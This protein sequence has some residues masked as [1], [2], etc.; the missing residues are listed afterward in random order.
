MKGSRILGFDRKARSLPPTSCHAPRS[1]E[2]FRA[3]IEQEFCQGSGIDPE[4]FEATIAVEPNLKQLP[5]GEVETPLHNA[6]NWQFRRFRQQANAQQYGALFLNE[7]GSCW[8]A[9]L[10]C[11]NWDAT[12]QQF[13]KYES[14]YQGGSRAYLPVINQATRRKIAARYG[15]DCPPAGKSFWRWL[16]GHPEIPIIW[17]EGGKKALCLL[18]DGYVAIALFGV[19]GGHRSKD[20]LGNA[21]L[22]YL[23]PDVQRFCQSGR[24]HILAFDQDVKEQ[25]RQKVTKALSSLAGLLAKTGGTV[26]IAQWDPA[27]GKGVDNLVVNQGRAAWDQAYEQALSLE[28]WL[29]HT[30]RSLTYRAQVVVNQRYLG[31][32]SIPDSARLICLKAPKGTGKTEAMIAL[33]QEAIERGQRVLILT[34]RIQL[35][36]A[37]CDRFG[38]NYVTEVRDSQTGDLLGYG[39]CVDS[40]HP[41]SQAKFQAEHW[42][43]PLVILDEAEQVIWHTLNAATEVK[44]HRV[45]VLRELKQLLLNALHPNGKGRVI[46]SDADLTDLSIDLVK[47]VTG[48]PELTPWIVRN[49]WQ[50]EQ[51]ANIYHYDQ[52]TPALWYSRLKAHLQITCKAVLIQLSAQKPQ[53]TWGTRNV[54]RNLRRLFPEKRIL[55]IDSETISNPQHPAYGCISKLNEVLREYDIVI[56]SPS[57]ETGVSI[58]LVGHFDSVWGCFQGVGVTDSVRQTLARLRE[59]VDRHVWIARCGASRIGNGAIHPNSL[60]KSQQR[61]VRIALKLLMNADFDDIATPV[62]PA[63]ERTWARMACRINAGMLK[64]RNTVLQGLQEEG[65]TLLSVSP[66]AAADSDQLKQ[67]RDAMKQEATAG[68]REECLGVEQAEAITDAEAAVLEQQRAKTD[69]ERFKLRKHQLHQ[70]YGIEVTADLAEK[71]DNGWLPQIRLHYYLAIGRQYLE[72]RDSRILQNAIA[73]GNGTVWLPDLRGS[74]LIQQIVGMERLGILELLRPGRELRNSDADLIQLKE[75]LSAN[76]WQTKALFGLKINPNASAVT[77]ARQMLKKLGLHLEMIGQP[78]PRGRQTRV[79]QVVGHED[80][81]EAVFAAWLARDAARFAEVYL[82][83]TVNSDR[84]NKG[85]SFLLTPSDSLDAWFTPDCLTDVQGMVATAQ[86]DPA[87]L[88]EVLKLLPEAVL[89]H[90]GLV[91]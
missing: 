33:V 66:E 63:Y 9:K 50:P 90:L 86:D 15:C 2:A 34:H 8:Q 31:E 64:Y 80:S 58:D 44:R 77:V 61:A 49:D 53:S 55:R 74:L 30:Y 59:M 71:D 35:G 40:L 45:A 62:D 43:D 67:E 78:G 83:D 36:Q 52:T 60:F 47:G 89:K 21:V 7:D 38:I 54:E 1:L 88:S 22:P 16:E 32:L 18:S 25:T 75:R 82:L 85:D 76:Q 28:Q 39:V 73:S 79:Y 13:R 24:R 46:L 6:L 48:Q 5:G 81:R 11:P 3:Q 56:A 37:L 14:V 27:Q 87:M 65:H 23:I 57:I 51:G 17:T 70:R 19:Y 69:T 12:K 26:A 20:A 91:A 10:A 84:N 4:L 29:V 68:H 42:K 72:E 41:Q